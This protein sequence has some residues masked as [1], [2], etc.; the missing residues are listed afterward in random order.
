[1][2]HGRIAAACFAIGALLL[3]F[4]ENGI[5]RLVAIV[6]LFAAIALGVR[7]IASP[8]FLTADRDESSG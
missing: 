2:T 7:A 1:M 4:V 3:F 8:E 6:L 5:V